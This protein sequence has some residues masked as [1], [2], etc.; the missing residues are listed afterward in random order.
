MAKL[1]EKLKEQIDKF[2]KK[3]DNIQRQKIKSEKFVPYRAD[4][5]NSEINQMSNNY[6]SFING[7]KVRDTDRYSGVSDSGF[8]QDT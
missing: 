4:R 3:A 8:N 5:M 7:Y 6:K 2:N 1:N